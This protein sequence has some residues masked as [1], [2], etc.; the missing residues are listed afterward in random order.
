MSIAGRVA[1]ITGASSGIGLACAEALAAEGVAVVLGARRAD[2]LA[3]AVERIRAAGGRADAVTMDVTVEADVD[4]L[5]QH[6]GDAFGPVDIAICNAGFGFYGTLEQTPPAVMRR[7]MDVNFHGT[8]LTAR[9]VLPRFERQ[10]R[11]HL[12]FVSSIVGQRGIPLM[13]GY[14]A[15]KAAQVGLAEGLRSEYAGT[16]IH[17]SVVFPVS[18]TTEFRSAIEKDF[19]YTVEGQGPTQSA[20]QVAA[21]VVA[22]LR[23]PRPEVYPLWRGRV[24]AAM[25]ALAPG[26]TDRVVQRFSRRRQALPP[27]DGGRSPA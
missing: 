6:A 23:A 8:F 2:R 13:S 20:E 11:G 26:I 17:V 14:S 27:G 3:E 18:T 15:T 1:V 10:Q 12:I 25:N 22:C 4:R 24:L 7:M 9:A 19:G 5:V 16:G 21:A